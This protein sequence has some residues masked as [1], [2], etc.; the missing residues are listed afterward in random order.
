MTDSTE[1]VLISDCQWFEVCRGE[2]RM[3]L[4]GNWMNAAVHIDEFR[5]DSVSVDDADGLVRI[6]R[7]NT[8]SERYVGVYMNV[9]VRHTAGIALEP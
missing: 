2:F 3:S 8:R 6:L 5:D 7:H 4:R 9:E 1:L